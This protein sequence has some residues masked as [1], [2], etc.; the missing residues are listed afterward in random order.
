MAN[1]VVLKSP[2]VIYNLLEDLGYFEYF[3]YKGL[4]PYGRSKVYSLMKPDYKQ[5][6]TQYNVSETTERRK[7]LQF[8]ALY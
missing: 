6:E 4:I 8:I 2:L 1:G 3:F 5:A 7:S